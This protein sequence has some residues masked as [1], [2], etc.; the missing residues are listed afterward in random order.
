VSYIDMCYEV[1]RPVV[2]KYYLR[3]AINGAVYRRN[4]PGPE[5]NT[6]STFAFVSDFDGTMTSRDFYHIIIDKYLGDRGRKLY[7]ERK[8]TGK[9]D[10]E[11]LNMIFGSISLSYQELE[12]EILK[13]PLDPVIPGFINEVKEGGGRFFIVS[14]GTSYYIDI[15]MKRLNIGV[16]VISM[17][18]EHVNG[19]IRIT[20]DI[21]SPYYSAVFGLDKR[22]VVED[23]KKEYGT[24]YFAGDSEPDLEAAKAADFAFA[25]DELAMMLDR[26][27]H[28][29]AGYMTFSD[30][31][32][33]MRE[34]GRL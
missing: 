18:G 12:A 34:M 2:W 19:G 24:V 17:R 3:C 23:I 30:I 26:E 31:R 10:V 25:K 8:R 15:L 21:N 27:N 16:D 9:I 4:Q 28:P 22:R 32:D 29:Y 13:I 7:L 6:L 11:F 14:A 33:K 20:P 5:E 1:A